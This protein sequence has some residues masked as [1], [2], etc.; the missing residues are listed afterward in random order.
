MEAV[1]D[2]LESGYAV[3]LVGEKEIR[4]DIPLELLPGGVSEGDWLKLDLEPDPGLTAERRGK[5][6]N[7]LDKLKGRENS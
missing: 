5:I 4:V 7:L 6:Q 2:R 1:V 3:L